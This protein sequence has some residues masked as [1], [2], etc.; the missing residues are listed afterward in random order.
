MLEQNWFRRG[1]YDILSSLLNYL[2]VSKLLALR[3]CLLNDVIYAMID[4]NVTSHVGL[5]YSK[6]FQY[7][8]NTVNTLLTIFDNTG[9][10][11]SGYA[12]LLMEK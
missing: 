8:F 2:P 3:P 4:P 6:K 7:K 10:K 5:P 9:W 1:K 11:F 12:F